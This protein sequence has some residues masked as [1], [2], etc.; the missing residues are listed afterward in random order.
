MM[1]STTEVRITMSLLIA[2]VCSFLI[3]ASPDGLA[4]T[5]ITYDDGSTYTLTA[6]Q[7]VYV[8]NKASTLFKR[9]VQTKDTYFYAQ[10]PWASRDYVAEPTD[11]LAKGSHEWC[12]AFTPWANGLTFDQVTFNQSCDTNG[13]NQYA[14][15]DAQFE[16]SEDGEVCPATN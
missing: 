8:S 13:D 1:N 9:R 5:V 7:E 2:A 14:C 12:K 11:G 4:D 15:G 6:D 3:L 16:D 10:E